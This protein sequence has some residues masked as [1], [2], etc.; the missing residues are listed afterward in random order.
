M[1]KCHRG[2]ALIVAVAVLG[3]LALLGASFVSLARLERRASQQRLYQTQALLLARSGIEDVQAR[4]GMGQ[5]AEAP[6]ALYLGED[7]DGDG[8]LSGPEPLAESFRPGILDRETCSLRHALRPSWAVR[9]AS[10]P[11]LNLVDGRPRG[12]SGLLS[13]G[14]LSYVLKVAGEDGLFVNGGDLSSGGEHA[15]TYDTVLKRLLGNLAAELGPPLTRTDGENLVVLRP[16]GGWA[17]LDQASSGLG[18][19]AGKTEALRPYLAFHAWVDRKVIRPS[20]QPAWTVPAGDDDL[21]VPPPAPYLPPGFKAADAWAEIRAGRSDG[22]YSFVGTA[23]SGIRAF[24][25]RTGSYAPDFERGIGGGIVGRA[26]VDLNWARDKPPVLKALLKD[27]AGVLLSD[28]DQRVVKSTLDPTIGWNFGAVNCV[29]RGNVGVFLKAALD[30]A[31][32]DAVVA[33]LGAHTG[34][35]AW[36]ADYPDWDRTASFDSWDE[37]GRFVDLKLSGLTRGKRDLI[38]ANFNPNSDLNKFNPG[39][40][41]FKS[42]DKSDL[43]V[44]S[45]EFSFRTPFRRVSALGRVLDPSGRLLAHRALAATLALDQLRL[46]TQSEFC[47]GSLGALDL[48]GDETAFRRPGAAGFLAQT[49][50]PEPAWGSRWVPKGYCLQTYPEPQWPA[51]GACPMPAPYDGYLE[52]ATLATPET[53]PGLRF[54]ATWESGYNATFAAGS[55]TCSTDTGHGNVAWSLLS[56]STTAPPGGTGGLVSQLNMLYPDGL[57]SESQ[58]TPGYKAPGNVGDGRQGVLSFWYKPA[59]GPDFYGNRHFRAPTLFNLV[60]IGRLASWPGPF[61]ET[62]V[63]MLG[64][65][66]PKFGRNDYRW[67]GLVESRYT[68]DSFNTENAAIIASPTPFWG[69]HRWYLMTFQWNL[70]ATARADYEAFYMNDSVQSLWDHVDAPDGGGSDPALNN[71]AGNSYLP[72]RTT[73]S[74]SFYLGMRGFVASSCYGCAD[75]TFDEL[76]LYSR[77]TAMAESASLAATRFR[78]GRYLK[79]DEALD[80]ASPEY[81]SCAIPLPTGSRILRAD[82]T[83]VLPRP[84]KAFQHLPETSPWPAA[85]RAYYGTG[86]DPLAGETAGAVLSLMN[87][88]GAPLAGRFGRSGEAPL[89]PVPAGGVRVGIHIMPRLGDNQ[90]SWA[91]GN[92]PLL[93]SPYF[94]D[95][96]LAYMPPQG[97]RLLAWREGE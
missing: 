68:P 31:D 37:F 91:K 78:A 45:T 14:G 25:A 52:L 58:R 13:R 10:G 95:L 70:R 54:L 7:W 86:A 94:D 41:F 51:P 35:S 80:P 83:L 92:A 29:E 88:A 73:G 71:L 50:S 18:W 63:L 15:G 1:P 47:A 61:D 20:I 96:T 93:E 85:N 8:T 75:G 24:N 23:W 82:W 90:G 32:V 34:F 77:T 64:A 81:S 39:E 89:V 57:C 22:P 65:R 33:A 27:L 48:A 9:D 53:E 21:A 59:F 2:L 74:P 76:A 67:G 87:A 12:R 11:V 3:V 40:T 17:G 4:L 62:Q 72:D 44:Y 30:A 36:A 42:V 16:T 6:E 19:T 28:S 66:Q 60:R 43:T 97:P 26:P 84:L 49:G 56:A 5:D 79:E 46:T 55:A 38:K 69:A